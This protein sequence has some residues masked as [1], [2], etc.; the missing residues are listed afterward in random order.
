[1]IF[2]AIKQQQQMVIKLSVSNMP[3]SEKFYTEKLGFKV[4]SDYT[5]N[6]GGTFEKDS[7]VQLLHDAMDT[8][9]IGLFKDIDKP[10][11]PEETGTAPTFMVSDIVKT[12]EHLI[13]EGIEVSEIVENTSDKG[14]IDHFA[15]F[16]D[17]DNNTLAIRQNMN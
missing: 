13:A 4:Q 14:Y 15:F 10:L 5:I 12:R 9:A 2:K 16:S 6:N 11:A 7:Y 17:P 3:V 8:I 1:M